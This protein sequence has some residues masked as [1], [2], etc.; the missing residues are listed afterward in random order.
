MCVL[1]RVCACV[2]V[3][4]ICE[5]VRVFACVCGHMFLWVRASLCGCVCLVLVCMCACVDSCV[6]ACDCAGVCGVMS[7]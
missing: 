6:S 3:W 7:V 5:Y 4:C 1:A 2:R